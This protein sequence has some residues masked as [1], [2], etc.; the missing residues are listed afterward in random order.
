MKYYDKVKQ[1]REDMRYEIDG[2]VYKVKGKE[3]R[4]EMGATQR[5]PRWA[6]AHKFE[7][8]KGTSLLE[9]ITY[10][11]GRTG[12]ITPVI[13]F[14]EVEIGGVKVSRATG[15]NFRM[16]QSVLGHTPSVG[17][18]VFVE[19]AGDVIPKV[20]RSEGGGE[21]GRI[22]NAGEPN[23]CPSCGGEV[24]YEGGEDNKMGENGGNVSEGKVLRCKNG[25]R[26][27]K[28]QVRR[29]GGEERGNGGSKK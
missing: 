2:C 8:M 12:A 18:I 19:R 5:A 27:C 14:K 1:G 25:W 11:V 9:G 21:E 22:L 29:G 13:E 4:V 26:E 7:T 15:N 17:D 6:I 24:G 16:L 28:A 3:G 10:K 20:L 23:E